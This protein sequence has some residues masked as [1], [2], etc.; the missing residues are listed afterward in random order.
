MSNGKT[1]FIPILVHVLAASCGLGRG[2][3]GKR[4]RGQSARPHLDDFPFAEW[5]LVTAGYWLTK[6]LWPV[7]HPR[8]S[9]CLICY[10]LSRTPYEGNWMRVYL[11]LCGAVY[12]LA[13]FASALL[14]IVIRQN[15]R[16]L[17]VAPTKMISWGD[18]KYPSHSTE[19]ISRDSKS[20]ARRRAI[21]LCFNESPS[22]S[23][24]EPAA[25]GHYSL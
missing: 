8:G 22:R 4:R 12:G 7:S 3:P 24:S 25:Q 13:Y 23:K 10:G 21:R 19:L 5:A 9:G 16:E 6:K 20:T 18:G 2:N 15:S 17:A 1:I 11:G 14:S